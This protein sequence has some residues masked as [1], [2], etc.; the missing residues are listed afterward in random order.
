MH[1][2]WQDFGSTQP[3]SQTLSW[4]WAAFSLPFGHTHVSSL[5]I[6]FASPEGTA[7]AFAAQRSQRKGK[8][9]ELT[10]SHLG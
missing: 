8:Q 4:K 1:K 6:I 10:K 2:G 7:S 5:P 3:E 9:M